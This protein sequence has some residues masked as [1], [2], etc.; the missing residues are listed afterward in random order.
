MLCARGEKLLLVFGVRRLM[1]LR[2]GNVANARC[3]GINPLSLEQEGRTHC[4]CARSHLRPARPSTPYLIPPPQPSQTPP[5]Q[6]S[7]FAHPNPFQ[8]LSN[9]AFPPDPSHPSD[10]VSPFC[11]TS[12]CLD[13]PLPT[14]QSPSLS[15][16]WSDPLVTLFV[17]QK[18]SAYPSSHPNRNTNYLQFTLR[19]DSPP[20]CTC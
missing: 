19:R 6:L 9:E 18:F 13:L 1:G 10:F 15:V 4:W 11:L 2:D 3:W 20:P 7:R 12:D 8:P 14:V 5:P 17:S 16:S